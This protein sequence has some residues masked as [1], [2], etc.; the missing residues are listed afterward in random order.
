VLPQ[1][2]IDDERQVAFSRL[3]GPLENASAV[4]HQRKAGVMGLRVKLR[5]IFDI[6]NLDE[7]GNLLANDDSRWQ[8]RQ[9]NE[10]WHSDSSF[11]QKSAAWSLLHARVIPPSGGDTYFADTRA[12]YDALPDA[13]KQKLDGLQAE[14]SI[15]YSRAQRGGYVPTEAERAARPPAHH[16]LVRRHRGS[17]RK[18]LFIASHASH[19]IGWPVDEGRALLDELLAFATQERFVYGHKWR[20]GDLVIR[21]NRCTLHRATPFPSNDHKREMRRTTVVDTQGDTAAA[22]R[23]RFCSRRRLSNNDRSSFFGHADA[24]P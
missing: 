13:M 11:R 17:G 23:C 7:N 2:H 18:A 9:A 22:S 3:Y 15:W 14:H 5:E 10:L 6:S 4:V 20:I 16:P 8:Y 12:A 1:Q 24:R 21:D 19:I